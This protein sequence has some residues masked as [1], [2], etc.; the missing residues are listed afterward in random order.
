MDL[1]GSLA[2]LYFRAGDNKNSV[3]KFEQAQMLDPYLIKGKSLQARLGACRGWAGRP[4]KPG[5]LFPGCFLEGWLEQPFTLF[6]IP[7]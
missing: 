2:D 5:S 6:R 1:L 4:G 7:F 3:L